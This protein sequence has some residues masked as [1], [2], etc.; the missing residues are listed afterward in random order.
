MQCVG[1]F[2]NYWLTLGR[3]SCC[4]VFGIRHLVNYDSSG[5]VDQS[6]VN[7]TVVVTVDI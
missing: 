5:R 2:V 4:G 1:V 6:V 7:I 3:F